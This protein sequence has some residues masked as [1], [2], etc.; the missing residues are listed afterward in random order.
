MP[1]THR[2]SM[3]AVWQLL[4]KYGTVILKPCIGNSGYGIIQVSLLEEGRYAMQTENRK[5]VWDGKQ[6]AYQQIEKM[7][8]NR[9]YI[10]QQRIP[11]AQIEKRTFDIRVIV[12]RTNRK[13]P[14][15]VTGMYAKVAEEG[16]VV[17]NVSR[18]V[19][20]IKQAIEFATMKPNSTQ[21]LIMKIKNIC[22]AAAKYLRFY[23]PHQ[24]I[25]G[26]DIGLDYD[27]QV[28]IIEAN[29]KPSMKPFLLLK[30]E[31]HIDKWDDDNII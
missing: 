14:Y 12:Q 3:Q 29:F 6:A 22:L 19:I 10:V 26:F 2:L 20:P 11:L 28:W 24:R 13:V 15:R 21:V 17:T 8:R 7:T 25:I 9:S 31:Q 5:I 23:Y 16:Y 1:E 30:K 18:Q 27:A 4:E